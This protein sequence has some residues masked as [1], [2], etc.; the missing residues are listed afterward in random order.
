MHFLV[1][2]YLKYFTKF[3]SFFIIIFI[4]IINFLCTYYNVLECYLYIYYRIAYIIVII[5]FPCILNVTL[6][7]AHRLLTHIEKTTKNCNFGKECRNKR[8]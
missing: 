1:Y 7:V 8:I 4:F 5:S 6:C 3:N 2:K